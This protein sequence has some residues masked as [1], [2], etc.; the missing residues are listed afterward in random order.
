M[1]IAVKYGDHEMVDLLKK[2]TPPP[3]TE[4]EEEEEEAKA[5]AARQRDIRP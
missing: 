1:T 2:H 5:W 3:Q 4:E